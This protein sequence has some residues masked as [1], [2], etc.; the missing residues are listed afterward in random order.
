MAYGFND[1]KSKHFFG[2]EKTII[3]P[4]TDEHFDSVLKRVFRTI[5]TLENNG[6][7][8]LYVD[9]LQGDFSEIVNGRY[10]ITRSTNINDDEIRL[11]KSELF[12]RGGYSSTGNLNICSFNYYKSGNSEDVSGSTYVLKKPTTSGTAPTATETDLSLS[13]YISCR[14][15]IGWIEV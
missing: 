9:I 10:I 11:S 8:V 12:T 3:T 4:Q 7:D 1:D 14:I 15:D 2:V 13:T 6:S 5:R